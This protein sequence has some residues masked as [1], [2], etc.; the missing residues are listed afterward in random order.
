MAAN[1]LK[2]LDIKTLH[3]L[4]MPSKLA[5]AG[6]VVAGVL[7]LGYVALFR[8]QLEALD[9]AS[10]KEI[11]LKETYTKK[12]IE[13]ANLDNLKAE[14][15]AIRSSFNVLLK[16]LPTDAEIPNLIQELHQAGATN[17]LRMDSVAPGASV[18]D[19]PIQVLP[20]E[21]AITGKYSQISQFARD[22]GTLSRIITLESL[23]IS[24]KDDKS[25]LL[26]LSATANTYK[27]RPAEEVAAELEAA[28][29]A[30]EAQKPQ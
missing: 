18:N 2:N 26:T 28:K 22:V 6:L 29:A 23:K 13:A 5:L 8:S 9:A 27:A 14:L 17:G 24:N 16:Q 21:I 1:S 10:A 3:L 4:N 11:E 30:S 19:G 25:N 20:Y 7:V 15:D 12:S